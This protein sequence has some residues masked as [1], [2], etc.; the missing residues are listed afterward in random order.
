[1]K[2]TGAGIA[3]E[4]LPFIFDPFYR[5]DRA[6]TPGANHSG[7]GLRIARGLVEAHGGTLTVESEVGRGTRAAFTLP[8]RVPD[9]RQEG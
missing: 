4:H 8:I 6:R 7:L 9:G 3:A 1:V 2:D 5:A